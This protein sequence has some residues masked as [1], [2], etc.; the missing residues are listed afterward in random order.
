MGFEF[1]PTMN[2]QAHIHSAP[3]LVNP[4]GGSTEVPSPEPLSDVVGSS[5]K[6]TRP[7]S[8]TAECVSERPSFAIIDSKTTIIDL[9]DY[10]EDSVVNQSTSIKEKISVPPPKEIF[11]NT[12]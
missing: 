5:A 9:E 6:S 4:L 2:P 12:L 11:A 7:T 10:D 3:N 8:E 1:L